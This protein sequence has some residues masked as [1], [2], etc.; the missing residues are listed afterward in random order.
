MHLY[1]PS[2]QP[3]GNKIAGDK[4]ADRLRVLTLEA[5]LDLGQI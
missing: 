4:V 5:D 3:A 1:L 2:Q